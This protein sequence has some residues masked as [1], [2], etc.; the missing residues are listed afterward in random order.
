MEVVQFRAGKYAI[1]G[2]TKDYGFIAMM[3]ENRLSHIMMVIT[4]KKKSPTHVNS[5]IEMLPFISF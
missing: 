5:L 1:K 2:L 3:L 4:S